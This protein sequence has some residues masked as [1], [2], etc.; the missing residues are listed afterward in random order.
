MKAIYVGSVVAACE[1]T[2]HVVSLT[3]TTTP[4]KM[5]CCAFVEDRRVHQ[6][7]QRNRKSLQVC[8]VHPTRKT[9]VFFFVHYLMITTSILLQ[10]GNQGGFPKL[11]PNA[12]GSHRP[13]R[14]TLGS[15]WKWGPSDLARLQI[16]HSN[17]SRLPPLQFLLLSPTLIEV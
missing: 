8:D 14:K 3:P 13:R 2:A 17:V 15:C 7:I 9:M 1:C 4:T 12:K 6:G 10:L 16:H 11:L 5:K